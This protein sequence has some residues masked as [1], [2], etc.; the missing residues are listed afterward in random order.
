MTL[1]SANS[2]NAKESSIIDFNIN[3]RLT[4]KNENQLDKNGF[5]N[6]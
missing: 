2:R 4:L 5:T 3:R 1:L 6:C